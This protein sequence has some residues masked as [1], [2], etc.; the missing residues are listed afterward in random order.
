MKSVELVICDSDFPV[1]G[2]SVCARKQE[3]G[4]CM[5]QTIGLRGMFTFGLCTYFW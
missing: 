3:V 1:R 5:M 4:E 2:C